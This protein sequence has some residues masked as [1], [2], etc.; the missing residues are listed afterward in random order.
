MGDRSMLAALLLLLVGG[1]AL[2]LLGRGWAGPTTDGKLV[3][4]LID[5]AVRDQVAAA[6]LLRAHPELLCARTIRD[7]TPLHFCAAEG[8][9]EGVRFLAEAGMAVDATNDVGD[10]ALV[11][12]V[13]AGN[14]QV[15]RLLLR[16]GANPDA[17]SRARGS[18]L[19][20]AAKQGNARLVEALLAAGARADDLKSR[21]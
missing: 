8:L 19:H 16:H 2:L 12:A 6:L 9:M 11:D 14:L 15:T 7:E 3:R 20:I 13:T 21:C 4:R 1:A 5:L 17:A 10:T 18:V